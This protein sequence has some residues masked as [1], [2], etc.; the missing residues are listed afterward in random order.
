MKITDIQGYPVWNG[1]RNFLFVTVDTDEGLR[2]T[3]AWFRVKLG[4]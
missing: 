2:L 1:K 3:L 4:R